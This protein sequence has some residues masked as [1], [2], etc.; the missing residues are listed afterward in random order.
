MGNSLKT[1][2]YNRYVEIN[3]CF[4]VYNLVS[5]AIIQ[6]DGIEK[7]ALENNNLE[8]FDE[9]TLKALSASHIVCSKDI[10][11]SW[12]ILRL[13]RI[14]KFGN[15]NA[16]L[17]ILPTLNCNFRCWYCYEKHHSQRMGQMEI[18]AINKFG[19][20]LL[21][22]NHLNSMTLDW[23]GG[24]PMLCFDSVVAPLSHKIQTE[25][26]KANVDFCNMITTNGALIK[27]EHIS[28]FKEIALNQYQITLDGGR[29]IHNKTRY[30]NLHQDSFC[31]IINNVLMLVSELPNIDM[32]VRINCTKENVHSLY[33]IA[34]YFPKEYRHLIN[35]SL[36]MVWQQVDEIKSISKTIAQVTEF[37]EQEGFTVL[38]QSSMPPCPNLCYVD[39]M[40][41]Y[42]IAPDLEIYKCTARDFIPASINH[43]GTLTQE[44]KFISNENILFYYQHSSFENEKCLSCELLPACRVNC[45]QKHIEREAVNCQKEELSAAVDDI[46]TKI[47]KKK[48]NNKI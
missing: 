48:I 9:K 6:L 18:D 16:R 46:V 39:N 17:T 3:N 25:C 31:T 32:T 20:E 30:S 45:I 26:L 28:T 37:F 19:Q 21:N 44:G 4:Y 35:I 5:R 47:I 36:Q 13:H 11:E 34:N 1:S 23:F 14:I 12:H 2:L 15:R 7:K 8:L 24:E 43:I 22:N 42:T 38:S 41:Q 29:E 10:D 33:E 27:K 40:L